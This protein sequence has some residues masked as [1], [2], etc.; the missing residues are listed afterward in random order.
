LSPTS[1][2]QQ[3]H[4]IDRFVCALKSRGLRASA[5][6]RLIIQILRDTR[7]PL[8]ARE[9]GQGPDGESIGLD[10]A[11]VYRNLEVLEQHGL[12]HEIHP[13]KGPGRYVLAQAEDREYL[14]CDGCGGIEGVDAIEL[15]GVRALVRERYGY[16]VSFKRVPMVGRCRRCGSASEALAE[17]QPDFGARPGCR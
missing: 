14:V 12:V 2:L 8:S 15:D 11:S 3:R 7:T 1:S 4:S 13:G 5:S 10:L 6:R 17:N 16:E 9:I